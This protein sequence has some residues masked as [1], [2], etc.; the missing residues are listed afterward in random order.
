MCGESIFHPP[1]S[2]LVLAHVP[3]PP[4]ELLRRLEQFQ[5]LTALRFELVA[6]LVA[7]HEQNDSGLG[8]PTGANQASS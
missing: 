2:I 8:K 7:A 3:P 6:S 4:P 1:S 5:L